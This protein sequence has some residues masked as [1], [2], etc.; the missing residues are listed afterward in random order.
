[1]SENI[2]KIDEDALSS[3]VSKLRY[4]LAPSVN[5]DIEDEIE[6]I[7]EVLQNDPQ[8][9]LKS[10]T[11]DIL[12]KITQQ[13]I[14]NDRLVVRNKSIDNEKLT[15][16]LYKHF[17]ESIFLSDNSSQEILNIKEEIE[18]LHISNASAREL[19]VMQSKLI[20]TMCSFESALENHKLETIKKKES[21][22]NLEETVIKLQE[23]LHAANEERTLD[24][25]TKILNRRAFEDEF[26]KI[27]KKHKIFNSKY[28]VIFYDIDHFKKVNDTYG[29][30][31]GDEV[32]K[33]FA[34]VLK[35]LTRKEDSVARYGG[36]EFIVLLN[37]QDKKEIEKYIHR[38]RELMANIKF[39]CKDKT[40]D[41]KFSA[42][43]AFR[44]NHTTH[45]EAMSKA[46]NLLYDAK[47]S[48]RDKVILENGKVL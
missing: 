45:F 34:S 30:E 14:H 7:V 22:V 27:E 35:E 33:T 40:L 28:A 5:Y 46:D 10:D 39:R 9:I 17:E 3:L 29:H 16:L 2:E 41:I 25:L 37:Y 15:N 21:L 19:S 32:L 20:D 43:I 11:L 1:M 36:E 26:D 4:L 24:F 8:K 23:E 44:V 48:G 13:R 18:K 6:E 31:C 12:T 47:K 42:G 38:V